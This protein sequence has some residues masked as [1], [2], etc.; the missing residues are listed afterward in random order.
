MKKRVLIFSLAWFPFES[1]AENAPRIVADRLSDEY[2]FDVIAYRF[3]RNWLIVEKVG[4][5]TVYRVGRP[6][7]HKT[8]LCGTGSSV[9]V[10]FWR[11]NERFAKYGYIFWGFIKAVQLHSK[12]PYDLTWSIMAGYTGGIAYW[13]K[14]FNP[15]VPLLLTLQEGD[16]FEHIMRRAGITKYWF[17]DLFN[18]VDAVHAISNYLADFSKQMGFRG[19]PVVV[20]NGVDVEKFSNPLGSLAYKWMLR[21]K[22]QIILINTSRLVHKNA[23]D[24]IIRALKLLPENVVYKNVAQHGDLQDELLE[25]ARK[26]GV[27]HRVFLLPGLPHDKIAEWLH[28]GDILVRPSRTEGLGTSFIEAMAAGLP[29][30][31]TPVG[32]IPDFLINEV[33][34]LFAEVD[35]PESVAECI[36]RLINDSNLREK[37]IKNAEELAKKE[38]D[39]KVV[40]SKLKKVID[41]TIPK[42]V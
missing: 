13:F 25:L 31:A 36:K 40:A 16:P 35:N 37:I 42:T 34:G 33:T 29:I 14:V 2:E 9:G 11:W 6:V 39:W 7:P 32:G 3:K 41:D 27:S 19:T 22:K 20:P 17:R 30:V 23:H 15:K 38:Y 1:G 24:I 4:N 18:K 28:T 8:A 26:E 5:A 10:Y 12:N 21:D